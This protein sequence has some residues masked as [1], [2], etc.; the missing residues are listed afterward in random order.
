M[1]MLKDNKVFTKSHLTGLKCRRKPRMYVKNLRRRIPTFLS[2][3]FVIFCHVS[4]YPAQFLSIQR[5]WV[6]LKAEW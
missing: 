2:M 1:L 3:P 6:F 5:F 4:R